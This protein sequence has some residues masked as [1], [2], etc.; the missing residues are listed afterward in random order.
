[1]LVK[2]FGTVVI[3]AA[4]L[5][6]GLGVLWEP[7]SASEQTA[8]AKRAYD[9]EIVRDEFGVPHI[10][11]KTDADAAYGLAFAHAE[12]DFSGIEEVIA[13][14]RG[15]TG[16]LIGQ[17]GAKID[18][19]LAL[20]GARETAVRDYMKIPADVRLVLEGYAAGLNHYA[21][22]HPD[23]Q[24]LSKLFPVNGQDVATGF[25]L[26]APFFYGL[27]GVIGALAGDKPPPPETAAPMTPIGRDPDM[28]GS[29]A[30]AVAPKRMADGKTWLISN[31]HQPYEGQ[32]AWYEAVVHSGEGLDMAGALFPGSPFVLLGHNRN[33]GWTNT[34]NQPDLID[35]YKLTLNA[36]GDQYQYDGAWKPLEKKRIWIPVK[37]GPV[38][39]PIPKTIYHAIQGPVIINKDGA[40]AIR[41]A[42]MDQ[43]KAVEQYFRNTKAKD[44]AEWTK[45]M[46]L[47]GIP[48]T[49]F[50]YADKTGRI[51]YIYY[52]LFPDRKPGFDYTKV[53]AGNTSA[54]VWTGALGFDRM[55][56]LVDPASGF[57]VNSNNTPFMAAGPGSEL[58]PKAFSPLL[59][60]ERRVTNRIIRAEELL[61]ADKSITPEALLAI[62]F[63]TVYSRNSYAGPW[64]AKLLSADVRKEPDLVA[65]QKL[66]ATW[67]W[68]SDGNGKADALGE[69]MM[70]MANAANY[71]RLPLPDAREKLR[72]VVD[73][74]MKGFG[75]IDPPLSAVQR[76]IRGQVNLPANGGTDTLRAATI[77]EPQPDG[78]MRVRHGDSFIM[79]TNWDKA[80]TVTSQSIQPYGAATNRP[81]SPHYTDQMK[82]FEDRKFKPVHFE[83][84]DAVAHAKKRYR[85]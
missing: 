78:T 75:R 48:A 58:D 5:L 19:V 3:I 34:V 47:G 16:A 45:S 22:T 73:A 46:S 69:A 49:N 4:A 50:I 15:R 11:G 53:L 18:Y 35:V 44:W 55:P 17:D 40:F 41:Y 8:P 37:F 85:P 61:S 32:V 43:A 21:D 63:D 74:L 60:I 6:A 20:L 2:K 76:L 23:E 33:L 62:K 39:V 52:A 80:G 51:A 67:D 14:T 56:K 65:A 64:V 68:N 7:L 38:T 30:F 13:M 82:M 84:A 26:R 79:L 10:N 31:S 27:D 42:G 12:D 25:V 83:W 72:E 70:H 1:L 29:N 54:D 28:N 59:G 81:N 77:W 36:A 66:L 9:V 71:K 24:R 57:L